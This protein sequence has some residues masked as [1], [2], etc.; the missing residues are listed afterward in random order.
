MPQCSPD[1]DF[2]AAAV[3]VVGLDV[4]K[5]VG[6]EALFNGWEAIAVE[7]NVAQQYWRA[8]YVESATDWGNVVVELAVR[9]VGS[10]A[11]GGARA[12]DTSEPHSASTVGAIGPEGAVIDAKLARPDSRM[13]TSRGS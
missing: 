5:A 10:V 1:A 6:S 8:V 12:I 11:Q 4:G 7:S 9:R 13:R 2:D 3:V